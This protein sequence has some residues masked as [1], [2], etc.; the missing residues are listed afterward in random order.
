[1]RRRGLL[2]VALCLFGIGLS[3]GQASLSLTECYALARANYPLIKRMD[4]ID[5]SES[6]SLD[7]AAK[8]WLPQVNVSAQAS[9]QSDVTKLPFDQEKISALIPALIPS[10]P[11]T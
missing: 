6:Y 3:A 5:R 1:M 7:N 9:Y 2:V 8:A 10:V 11:I 4:L